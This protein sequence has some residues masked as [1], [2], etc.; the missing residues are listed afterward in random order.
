M[1]RHGYIG[2][3][4]LHPS[5]AVSTRALELFHVLS[6]RCP[7]LSVQAFIKFLCDLHHVSLL[8]ASHCI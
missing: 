3:A 7:Q 4:P 2:S 1:A 6:N 8:H 5:T